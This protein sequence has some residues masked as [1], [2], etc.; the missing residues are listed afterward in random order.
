MGLLVLVPQMLK[1]DVRISL[2]GGEARVSEELL[3]ASEVSA[4]FEKMRRKTMPQ[5][6]GC[7]AAAG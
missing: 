4:S 2:C 6:V 7:N 3:D 1:T 5:G